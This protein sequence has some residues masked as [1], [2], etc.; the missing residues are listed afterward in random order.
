M[1]QKVSINRGDAAKENVVKYN[2]S[3]DKPQL[4]F[5]DAVDN[6]DTPFQ[7][8]LKIKHHSQIEWNAN[9]ILFECLIIS[10]DMNESGYYDNPYTYE[11]SSALF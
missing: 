7:P 10:I 8:K 4:S 9:G 3:L 6:T 5:K 1:A 2:S 11:I